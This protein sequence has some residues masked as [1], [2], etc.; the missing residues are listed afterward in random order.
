MKT[1]VRFT[2]FLSLLLIAQTAISL[3]WEPDYGAPARAVFSLSLPGGWRVSLPDPDVRQM[4]PDIALL[5]SFVI[6]HPRC[7]F[8]WRPSIDTA[9]N[10]VLQWGDLP[11]GALSTDR[12]GFINT[13]G[14]IALEKAGTPIDVIGVGASYMGGA[15][16]TFHEY[17]WLKGLFYYNM[18]QG[19]YTL[20]L[21]NRVVT[22]LALPLKPRR[23]L[24]G[25][26]EVSHLL[27]DDCER[28]DKSGQDWM[29]FHSGSW[30]GPAIRSG[31]PYDQLRRWKPVFALYVA[32]ERTVV[33][34][35][36][37]QLDERQ[38]TG[39]VEKSFGYI[40][41]AWTATRAA[42][43]EFTVLM[44]PEKG[45]ALGG[46]SPNLYFFERMEP[47][48]REAGI[49][50]VDL[51]APFAS[52]D[53]PRDLYFAVDNHWNRNG[54]YLAAQEMM[55]FLRESTDGNQGSTHE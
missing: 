40:H 8:V 3:L 50:Y 28:W 42:G 22:D 24:Y 34:K 1:S 44:I 30:C 25:L 9:D 7:G 55:R 19:R 45:R 53:D 46:A 54:I 32:I 43:V 33:K 49:Q 29:T 48:L 39:L 38:K 31:F 23:I 13:P 12:F 4:G 16:G 11:S 35:Q 5:D 10:V 6:P 52:A 20:P 18:A 41:E 26:N 21:Y 17:F 51:R 27:I 37:A 14:A 2:A 15:A 36:M 47:L